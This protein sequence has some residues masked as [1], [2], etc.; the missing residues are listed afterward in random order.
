M[1]FQAPPEPGFEWS[2]AA[3]EL[4][5]FL[6]SFALYGAAGFGTLV[7]RR[8]VAAP[9]VRR[10][11]STVGLVGVLVSVVALLLALAGTAARKHL[12]LGGAFAAG[13][14][15]LVAQVVLL[16]IALV[17]FLLGAVGRGVG[18]VL[19]FLASLALALRGIVGGNW[20][21]LVK[22]L[23]VLAGGLWIGTLFVLVVTTL[24]VRPRWQG[25]A[26][27]AAVAAM[28]RRFSRLALVSSALL[29]LTGVVTA[30]RH[31][32][33]VA[34]LWTTPYGWALDAKLL[35]VIAVAAMGAWNWRA[36]SPRLGD[37]A[38]TDALTRSSRNELAL[39]LLVLVITSVLVSLPAPRLPGR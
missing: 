26:H 6:G 4:V 29:A 24:V 8:D 1:L 3:R 37:D 16:A 39:A 2:S 12:S 9:V 33:Y 10:R 17:G 35:V 19:A 20:T 34:A 15:A 5:G 14:G 38:A 11:A 22:P 28:V 32:K 23:H 30:W 13:G 27:G 21:R 31:L 7:L 36:V 18:W 25:G